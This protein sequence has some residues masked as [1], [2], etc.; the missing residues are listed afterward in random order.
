MLDNSN[1][2]N[3]YKPIF[4][5]KRWIDTYDRAVNKISLKKLKLYHENL[6][7]INMII[8]KIQIFNIK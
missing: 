8:S 1:N 6:K 3:G 7:Y 5:N 2:V 4:S